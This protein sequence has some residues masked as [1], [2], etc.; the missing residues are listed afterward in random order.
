MAEKKEKNSEFKTSILKIFAL[1]P[2][3]LFNYKQISSRLGFSDKASKQM[4]QNYLKAMSEEDIISEEKQG[5]YKLNP[6]YIT[7]NVLPKHYVVGIV[8]MKQTGKA[9]VLVE[10][11]EDIYISHNNTNHALHGDKV[12]VYLFPQRKNRKR[13]GQII[14]IIERAK[15][16]FVGII[17]MH[18]RYAFV[19]PDSSYMPVD[20]FIPMDCVA[21]AKNGDKVLAEITEWPDSANNPFGKVVKVLGK[22][23]NNDVEMQSILSE[24]DFPLFFPAEVEKE[25]SE[26]PVQLP[27]SEI[28]NRKDFRDRITFTIDP[29][30]AKDFDDALSLEY[31]PNGNYEVG[32]HIADVSYYVKQGGEIDKQAFERGTSVYLVDRTIPMLPE[33][34][35]NGVCSLRQGE[36]KFCFSAVFEMTPKAEIVNQWIGKTIIESNRRFI[37]QEAQ[38]VIEEKGGEY[39]EYILPLWDL[40]E[41]MRKKRFKAGAINFESQEVKFH[42]DEKAK[43]IGVYVKE[44][45]EA[46]WLIEEFM[47]LANKK[48]AELIGKQKQKNKAKT[49]VY[50]VHDEP[51]QE[52]LN[53]FKELI[54]K[55]GYSLNDKTRS[56]LAKSFN[57]LFEKINGKGEQTMISM[58]ALRTMSKA[59]YT[60]D[61]IGHYGLGFPYYTHFTSPI[62]RYPD[63]MVHRLLEL[64]LE[65]KPSVNKEVFEQRCEH[66]SNME[67]K[68]A[69]AERMSVKYKQAE[70]LSDKVGKVFEGVISGVS[71]WGIYVLLDE[72]KCEGLVPIKTI[73]DDFYALDEDN[74][75][76]VGKD[77]GKVYQLGMKIKIKI[78]KVN[79]MKKQ[80]DFSIVK[81]K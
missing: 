2:N 70:F 15:T 60:T 5:K 63:L 38:K 43:P 16:S 58:I 27:Q 36:E 32:V 29:D 57:N 23:G 71:K 30:D 20:I 19:V 47:L 22:P 48:V 17:E 40:A 6:V 78:E 8:D 26:I 74:F 11:G 37:Y 59:L 66:C 54:G 61:N 12:K 65:D 41:I 53:V 64:Y 80:M 33:K 7:S 1:N 75:R 24:F 55:F 42:L 9:Y 28:K 21:N 34:L 50:R 76:Y 67:K 51:N 62:R 46:N 31:L 4:V 39:S 18:P 49:F 72:S 77:T 3:S 13:E 45:K 10:E 52:K 69:E 68:A 35:C 44:S 73:N 14:E 81:E 56:S 25:A 79:M